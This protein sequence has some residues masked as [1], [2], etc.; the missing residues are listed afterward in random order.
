MTSEHA[1]VVARFSADVDS[2]AELNAP[3]LA[4]AAA[5][6]V[7]ALEPPDK[8]VVVDLGTGTGLM[9]NLLRQRVPHARVIGLDL[10]E[11]MLRRARADT[12]APVALADVTRLPMQDDT[13]AA[14]TSAFVLRFLTDPLAALRE[15]HRVLHPDGR[16]GIVVWGSADLAPQEALLDEVL[17]Q[18]RAPPYSS[19]TPLTDVALDEPDKLA[20]ALAEAGFASPQAWQSNLVASYDADSFLDFAAR[21]LDRYRQRLAA[22]DNAAR[23]SA[24]DSARQRLVAEL[25]P[26]FD[27]VIPVVYAVG[28]K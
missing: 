12:G 27:D 9:L 16:A 22:M 11:A 28:R 10:V 18:H 3:L 5:P 2:Y 15:Q 26:R 23:T 6:I 21:A 25:P 13:V 14:S 7:D 4:R 20:A 8:G 24:L 19:P 1:G 17:D